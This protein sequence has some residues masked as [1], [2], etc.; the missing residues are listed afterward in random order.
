MA[1]VGFFGRLSGWPGQWFGQG[2]GV[3]DSPSRPREEE[4]ACDTAG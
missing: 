2:R 4:P 1:G 3:E